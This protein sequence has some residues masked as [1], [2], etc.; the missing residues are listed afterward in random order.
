MPRYSSN[1]LSDHVQ[2]LQEEHERVMR[3]MAEAEKALLQKPKSSPAK[4]KQQTERRVRI[5]NVATIGIPRPHDHLYPG[6]KTRLNKR[7]QRRRKPEARM[8]Q[9]KFLL[10]CLL[11][12]TLVLFI[13]RNLPG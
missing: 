6:G 3:E 4:A 1:P 7:Q 9:V 2:R 11:L 13:W 8:A 5:N 12:A 10:L